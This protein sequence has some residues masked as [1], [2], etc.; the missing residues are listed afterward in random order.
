M[1]MLASRDEVACIPPWSAFMDLGAYYM[2]QVP[3]SEGKSKPAFLASFLLLRRIR[4]AALHYMGA[5]RFPGR[6]SR[7]INLTIPLKA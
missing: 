6:Q 3:M 7:G 1:D 4:T 5:Y 2:Q